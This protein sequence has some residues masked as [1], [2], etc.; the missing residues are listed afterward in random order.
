MSNFGGSW[1]SL[2]GSFK[3]RA[4]SGVASGWVV[5]VDFGCETSRGEE[6]SAIAGTMKDGSSKNVKAK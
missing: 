2:P 3:Y 5:M 6:S 1:G 4:T